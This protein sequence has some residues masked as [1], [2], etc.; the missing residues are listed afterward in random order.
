[1]WSCLI[2]ND[3]DDTYEKKNLLRFCLA[4]IS[5]TNNFLSEA[6][7]LK[8]FDHCSLLGS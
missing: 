6:Y 5:Q 7:I 8:S 3:E 2:S 1:M 4:N